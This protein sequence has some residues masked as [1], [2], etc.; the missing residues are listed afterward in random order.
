MGK[1]HPLPVPEG[2]WSV[3]SV[4]F[5]VELPEAHGYDA[6]MVVVDS[7]GKRAHF[8]PTHTTCTAMGAANLYRKHVWKL[9]GLPDAFIS[10]RGPH[11][12]TAYHPQSDGQTEH[13]NQELEQ[14]L[15]VFC[16]ER[17]DDWDDLLPEAEFQ[18]NNHVHS[19]TKYTPFMLDTGRNPRMGFEPR[20]LNSNNE[21]ANEFF[22]RM[23][24]AQE[25]VKAALA[26]AK[27]DMARYYDQC[28]IPAL[29]HKPGDRVYLDT[30]D[31]QTTC[32]SKKLSHRY[33]GPYTIKRQVGPL[34]YKLR[35]PRSMSR[36]HPVF[37]AVK[38]RLAPPDPIPGR[39]ARLPPPPTLI[40]NKEW[41][42]VEDILDS[43]F[44]RRKLQYKVKW[45]GYGYE[46]ASWEPVEN[47]AHARNLVRE[48]HRRHP[49]AP[50][51]VCRMFFVDLAV[52]QA[53]R[54]LVHRGAAP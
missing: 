29:E 40:D 24:L 30:S 35:L 45:K 50:K 48:F 51:Q 3:V 27:D 39:R 31:I 14:Y 25:E 9:H 15:R 54:T 32:P 12:S 46:D 19:A 17:Q 36:L 43:R 26:K 20:P 49:E 52:L 4:D 1:L 2:R 42:D 7:V 37:N 10:D 34:A 18:Y 23:K 6:V 21:T 33:L 47:V 16:N 38:L 22:E 41:F 53:A 5:I 11:T 13:V 44:F 8:I 28:R